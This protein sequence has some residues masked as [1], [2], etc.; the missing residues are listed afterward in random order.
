MLQILK[1]IS[2]GASMYNVQ[3]GK[4]EH[5]QVLILTIH[6]YNFSVKHRAQL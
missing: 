4:R 2:G 5:Y 1:D 3:E 6:H